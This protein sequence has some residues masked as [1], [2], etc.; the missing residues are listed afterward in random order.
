MD[1]AK[2]VRDHSY[3]IDP[4]VRSLL[5]TDFYKILM[6]QFLW[7]RYPNVTT[8]WSVT[9]RTKTIKLSDFID[10]RELIAQLNH[11]LKL[12]FA[13]SELIWLKGQTFYGQTGIFTNGF[14]N[15]LSTMHLPNFYVGE[16]VN[17]QIDLTFRGPSWA[18]SLWEIYALS[19]INELYARSQMASMKASELDI[20]YAR[21]KVRLYEDLEAL[22]DL[23]ELNLTDFG[24]RRRHGFLWQEHCVLTAK[25]VLGERF[26]GTS[27]VYLAYKH[28][29]E[30]KGTNAHE[31]PMMFAGLTRSQGGTAKDLVQSQYKVLQ[32][33]QSMYQ[34]NLL[35]FLPDT[36]GTSQFL[37]NAP[38]WVSQ[39]KGA[40]PDSKE[41]ME[42]GYEL[43]NYWKKNGLTDEAIAKDKLIIFSD[44]LTRDAIINI[45][46]RFNGIVGIGFGW[47]TNFTNNF[48]GTVPNKPDAMKAI[49]L[50]C[51]LQKVNNKPCVKLSD[52]SGKET[53]SSVEE[54]TFY[55]NNFG[56]EGRN[57]SSIPLV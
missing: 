29:L 38:Q 10:P 22:A 31:L 12:R 45:Y 19:I 43:I 21:A 13:K 32:E 49:S 20:M 15:A 44:G 36:F 2:R 40:R 1:F 51:K 39:W 8:T 57:D 42:A 48:A 14:I 35:V 24:T 26:T 27:N 18:V 47:G 34:G 56:K 4:I 50:V 33:W 28:D 11:V 23:P 5:D 25:E 52:V 9:N 54:I 37:R 16:E 53:S 17:G 3:R 6:S 7:T 41:P 55:L 30:P 46:N